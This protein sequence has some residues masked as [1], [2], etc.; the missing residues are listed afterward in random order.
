MFNFLKKIPKE[1][2]KVNV[3]KSTVWFIT[4]YGPLEGLTYT[5]FRLD[6]IG[7]DGDDK[8]R[9]NT[10][11][12]GKYNLFDLKDGRQVPTC[13]VSFVEYETVDHWIEVK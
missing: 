5:G 4:E 2:K 3:K 1:P 12:S 11:K 6:M 13:R 9:Y 7:M 8:A 10:E